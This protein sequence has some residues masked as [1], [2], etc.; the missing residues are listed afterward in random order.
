MGCASSKD[1]FY[2]P[3]QTN[4]MS[5]VNNDSEQYDSE[6]TDDT[7][8]LLEAVK[9]KL[10]KIKRKRSSLDEKIFNFT[11]DNKHVS[12]VPNRKRRHNSRSVHP[13]EF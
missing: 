11:E 4:E 1:V 13:L 10:E 6:T 8:Q 2:T 3:V 9:T 5:K 12:S 7:Y